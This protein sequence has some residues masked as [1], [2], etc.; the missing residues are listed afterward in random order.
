MGT[1][2]RADSKRIERPNELLQQTAAAIQKLIE[3]TRRLGS[4]VRG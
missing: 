1:T 3:E 4:G 2:F